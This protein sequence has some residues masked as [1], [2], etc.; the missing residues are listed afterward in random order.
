MLDIVMDRINLDGIEQQPYQQ[1]Y[2]EDFASQ[3]DGAMLNKHSPAAL[4]RQQTDIN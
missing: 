2:S 4:Q 1:T 3:Y